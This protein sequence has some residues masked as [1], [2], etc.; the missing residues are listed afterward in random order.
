LLYEKKF[1][2]KA[3]VLSHPEFIRGD[4]PTAEKL[5]PKT[6]KQGVSRRFQLQGAEQAPSY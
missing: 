6:E 3:L 4:S 1:L 2:E 5:L